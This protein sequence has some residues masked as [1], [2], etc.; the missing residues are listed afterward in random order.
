MAFKIIVLIIIVILL[1][2]DYVLVVIA[3]KTGEKAKRMY[4]AWKSEPLVKGTWRCD[5]NKGMVQVERSKDNERNNSKD[6]H[7]SYQS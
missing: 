3:Y 1:V 7:R 4:R 2:L 5:E 6:D